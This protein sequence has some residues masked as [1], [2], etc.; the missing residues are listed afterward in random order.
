MGGIPVFRHTQIVL[1]VIHQKKTYIIPLEDTDYIAFSM[2]N[3]FIDDSEL[4]GWSAA[5][6]DL[7]LM[8]LV[9]LFQKYRVFW[10]S[11]DFRLML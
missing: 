4:P 10:G 11:M 9:W 7:I 6:R 3:S 5:M 2:V 8:R 1:L